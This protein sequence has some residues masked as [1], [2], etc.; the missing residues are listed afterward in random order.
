ML[1]SRTQR[2]DIRPGKMPNQGRNLYLDNHDQ[3]VE[4]WNI[5]KYEWMEYLRK[6][7]PNHMA[8]LTHEV[9]RWIFEKLHPPLQHCSQKST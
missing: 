1:Y 9:Q 6:L 4:V 2:V 7:D 3:S 8:T 5:G